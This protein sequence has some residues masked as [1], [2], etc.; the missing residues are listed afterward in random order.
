MKKHELTT[1]DDRAREAEEL[2][3]EEIDLDDL[4]NALGGALH[5]PCQN[6]NW[7]FAEPIRPVPVGGL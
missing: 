5:V 6:N 2:A 7:Q 1:P 3:I 4:K